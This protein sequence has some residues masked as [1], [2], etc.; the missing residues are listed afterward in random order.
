MATAATTHAVTPQEL[1]A[2]PDAKCFELVD[3]ELVEKNV[4]VLSSL[5]EGIVYRRVADYC[6]AH[7]AGEVWPGTLGLQCFSDAPNRISRPDVTF[8]RKDRFKPAYFPDGYL[9]IAPDLVAEVVS[10]DDTAYEMDEKV[11]Q[12]LAA[13]VALVWVVNPET[14]IVEIHRKDGSVTKLHVHEQLAGEDVLPGFGCPV[15]TLF[16]QEH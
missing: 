12:Y 4:S 7:Q 10:P 15:Q 14:K 2:M 1:L 11:E 9:T 5:V 13:G 16:S 6:D 8:V 3:G